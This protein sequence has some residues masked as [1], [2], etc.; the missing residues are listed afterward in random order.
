MKSVLLIEQQGY[1][2][3]GENA[4]GCSNESGRALDSSSRT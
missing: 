1:E 3:V 2:A 4:V